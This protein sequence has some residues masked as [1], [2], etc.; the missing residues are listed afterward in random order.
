MWSLLGGGPGRWSVNSAG[1]I[2]RKIWNSGQSAKV[3]NM[4]IMSQCFLGVLVTLP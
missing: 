1:I 4:T 3:V 2:M